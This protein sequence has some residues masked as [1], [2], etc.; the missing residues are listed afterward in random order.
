MEKSV[1]FKGFAELLQWLCKKD[2]YQSVKEWA[3]KVRK[4]LILNDP[5]AVK[6]DFWFLQPCY[7]FDTPI[8]KDT[9]VQEGIIIRQL[10]W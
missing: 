9:R 5:K 10:S 1:I 4:E 7:Y 2:G 3:D 6:K 8:T